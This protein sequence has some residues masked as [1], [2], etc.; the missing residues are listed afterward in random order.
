[1]SAFLLGFIV[2]KVRK[3]DISPRALLGFVAIVF[4]MAQ[5]AALLRVPLPLCLPWGV[6]AAIST[7]TVLSYAVLADFFPKELAGRA[8]AALNVFHIGCAFV[9]QYV[10]GLVVQLWPPQQGHYPEV[11]YQAAFGINL[12]VQLVAWFW[13]LVPVFDKGATAAD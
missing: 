2:H 3:L 9:A 6:V 13:F 4:F 1:M 12:A 11:A 8:N 10:T 5:G 7:A